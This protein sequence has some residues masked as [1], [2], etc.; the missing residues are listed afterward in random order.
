MEKRKVSSIEEIEY[1]L[2]T[3]IRRAVFMDQSEKKIGLLERASYLLLRHL[4]ETGP[5]QIKG[6]AESFHLDISTVSRQVAAL[7]KKAFIERYGSPDDGRVSLF[8]MTSL[9]KETLEKDQKMRLRRY[10]RITAAWTDEEKTIFADLISRM[11]LA[12]FE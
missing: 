4:K 1:Q 5:D 6:M 9:G 12:F 11:N 2:T 7:E 8:K 3:F 10:E